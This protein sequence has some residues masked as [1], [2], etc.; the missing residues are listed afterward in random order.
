MNFIRLRLVL[1]AVLLLAVGF[2]NSAS[3][4]AGDPFAGQWL[5]AD[6]VTVELSEVGQA[7]LRTAAF[8]LEGKWTFASSEN[9]ERKYLVNWQ[10][11]QF[12]DSL[13]LSSDSRHLF[14]QNQIGVKITAT[15]IRG[16]LP[17]PA[18]E[19]PVAADKHDPVVGHWIYQE[20]ITFEL[21]ED[22]QARLHSPALMLEGRWAFA[23]TDG[24]ERKYV[25]M[26]QG[27][28]YV[29]SLTLASDS[30]HLFGQN[31]LGWK[32]NATR[33]K[34][35]RSVAGPVEPA[36]QTPAPAQQA[37]TGSS[38][39]VP[40]IAVVP[41]ATA[42]AAKTDS[43][44][45]RMAES[46][47]PDASVRSDSTTAGTLVLD[48]AM[49]AERSLES[50]I[51]RMEVSNADSGMPAGQGFGAIDFLVGNDGLLY[52]ISNWGGRNNEG[53]LF[54]AN[55]DLSGFSIVYSVKPGELSPRFLVAGA[56][57]DLYVGG[58]TQDS[59]FRYHP[60]SQTTESGS[61]LSQVC[62]DWSPL[63][64]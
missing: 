6:G 13:T 39:S 57:G 42:P 32:L 26:W 5:W 17:G 41:K 54:K 60:K 46:L 55:P 25:I 51:K 62:S 22:G 59:Y 45:D 61:Y 8:G 38:T 20:G 10:G 48:P 4:K 1:A 52:G 9:G 15:R 58:I 19:K 27:G 56:N 34:A 30:R 50:H 43:G 64:L 29:D 23:S 14:G 18:P 28:Q 37:A 31:Q 2:A 11:G 47:S 12:I 35:D 16:P 36:S 7:R 3:A 21:L 49:A 33:D 53:V 44:K 40:P 63:G 24:G